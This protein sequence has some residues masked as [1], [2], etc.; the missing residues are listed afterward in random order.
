MNVCVINNNNNNNNNSNEFA[1]AFPRVWLFIHWFQIEL[2]FRS[3]DFCGGR[4]TGEPREKPSEQGQQPTTNSTHMWRQVW[5][6]NPGHSGGRRVL[7]PRWHPCSLDAT[8]DVVEL[9]I[10]W[11]LMMALNPMKRIILNPLLWCLIALIKIDKVNKNKTI[12]EVSRLMFI[13]GR[14]ITQS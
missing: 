8:L 14:S 4:K 9:D 1:V 2:E 5:E 13:T 11:Q 3:V 10:F 12:I 7:S 6:S